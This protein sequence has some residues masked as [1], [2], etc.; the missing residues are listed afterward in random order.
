MPFFR[1]SLGFYEIRYTAETA[2]KTINGL[3]NINYKYVIFREIR[4]SGRQIKSL[5]FNILRKKIK[6]LHNVL[7]LNKIMMYNII[8]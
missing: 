2:V 5:F 8:L 3:M 6:I 1:K 4:H 7:I